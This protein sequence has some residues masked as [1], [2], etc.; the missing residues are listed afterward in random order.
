MEVHSVVLTLTDGGTRLCSGSL[1]NNVNQDFELYFLT[2]ETCLGGHEI[3]SLCLIMKAHHAIIKMELQ[4]K[5]YHNSTLLAHHESDFA[6]LKLAE[7][8]RKI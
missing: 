6:L 5:L 3:G 2:S 4:T 8:P 1:L 7:T